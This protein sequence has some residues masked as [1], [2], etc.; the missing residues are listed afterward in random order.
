MQRQQWK[1]LLYKDLCDLRWNGQIL[2]NTLI[3]FVF[4]MIFP[5]I[6]GQQVPL[7]FLIAFV[8]A[9]VTTLMQGNMVVEEY[10]QK[11]KQ[12]LF[13]ANI[14]PWG[15]ILSKMMLTF[16]AT[17]IILLILVF[18]Y[19]RSFL[20]GIGSFL[21]AL[22]LVI[23]LL[24]MSTVLGMKSKNT[25]EVSLYGVPFMLLYFFI[26]GLMMNS[27]QSELKWLAIFPNYHLHYGIV[28]LHLQQSFMPYL[29]VP[30][31]WM[32]VIIL[33]FAIWFRKRHHS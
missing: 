20:E 6:P 15:I 32:A 14:S 24:F 3:A 4:I 11:T 21:M 29:I 16:M 13:Q 30:L 33:L 7:S 17:S 5:M 27:D 8:L 26:E 10:E 23:I 25:I 28:H 9:L 18:T 1:A 31:L 2:F 22:P 12:R 19:T